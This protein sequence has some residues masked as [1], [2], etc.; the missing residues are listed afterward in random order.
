MKKLM[1]SVVAIAALS[2]GAAFAQD[3]G[4][5]AQARAAGQQRPDYA[6]VPGTPEYYGNSGASLVLQQRYPYG[7]TN[8][9]GDRV[10]PTQAAPAYPYVPPERARRRDRDGDGVRDARDRDRDGDGVRNARDRHPD[11]PRRW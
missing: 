11:D 3:G 9:F 8:R 5:E 7:Y 2:T 6:P 10:Y 4:A 1:L